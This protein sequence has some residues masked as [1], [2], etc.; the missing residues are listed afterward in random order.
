[1]VALVL[2]AALGAAA[3]SSRAVAEETQPEAIAEESQPAAVASPAAP[4]PASQAASLAPAEVEVDRVEPPSGKPKTLRFLSENRA[5]LRAQLDQLR[6]LA[7]RGQGASADPLDPRYL[8]YRE[9]LAEVRASAD[10]QAAADDRLARRAI[11]ES[12]AELLELEAQ[13]DSAEAILARQGERLAWIDSDFATRHETALIVLVRGVPPCGAPEAIVIREAN[14]DDV[15]VAL[16]P[17]ARE[18]LASGG[19]AQALHAFVEPREHAYEVSL[20]GGACAETPSSTVTIDPERD[21]LNFLE[22]DLSATGPDA[23]TLRA[24]AWVR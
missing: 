21:R 6:Q 17:E 18:A 15:R 7:K 12:V 20:E 22:I 10:S 8:K 9:M 2:V 14:G 4:A 11:L 5:F 1:M 19:I 23:A 24:V 3:P 13:V 16:S